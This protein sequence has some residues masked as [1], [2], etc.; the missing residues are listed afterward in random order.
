M[1]QSFNCG[2]RTIFYNKT[3]PRSKTRT[4]KEICLKLS[5]YNFQKP[6][7]QLGMLFE[8]NQKQLLSPWLSKQIF[9]SAKNPSNFHE[10]EEAKSLVEKSFFFSIREF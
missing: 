9:N 4:I 6:L 5:S 3:I 8:W 1:F 7:H 2:Y 10:N